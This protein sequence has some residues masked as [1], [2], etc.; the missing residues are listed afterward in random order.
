MHL[1]GACSSVDGQ[2]HPVF[3]LLLQVHAACRAARRGVCL[4]AFDGAGGGQR[5]G[6]GAGL[7][8][9]GARAGGE[10]GGRAVV[11]AGERAQ[12]RQQLRQQRRVQGAPA[13]APHPR[14]Q[15]RFIIKVALRSIDAL[16]H[17]C[18]KEA[19]SPGQPCCFLAPPH[20]LTSTSSSCV[21][22]SGSVCKFVWNYWCFARA[23][24]KGSAGSGTALLPS[25]YQCYI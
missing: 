24:Q 1:R 10:G 12:P 22:L 11:D 6:G 19:L 4:P 8:H 2:R 17:Y 16:Q 18:R 9:G 14:L 20:T 23:L 25:F 21:S 7:Q 5:G 15:L 3:L 13:A